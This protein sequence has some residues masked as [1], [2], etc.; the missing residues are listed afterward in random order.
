LLTTSTRPSSNDSAWLTALNASSS[1]TSTKPWSLPSTLSA[2]GGRAIA[3]SITAR[4]SSLYGVAICAA[5]SR[6]SSSPRTS[7]AMA[8]VIATHEPTQRGS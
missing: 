7:P 8:A 1:V 2:D 5:R 3:R 6:A 4:T